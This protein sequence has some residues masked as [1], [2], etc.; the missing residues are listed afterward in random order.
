MS[1]PSLARCADCFPEVQKIALR[2]DKKP[3]QM[4]RSIILKIWSVDQEECAE[5]AQDAPLFVLCVRRREDLLDHLLD[6]RVRVRRGRREAQRER[7]V[8]RA[9]EHSVCPRS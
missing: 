8:I 5:I 3:I 4:K 7:E 1:K 2:V 9:Y 6:L